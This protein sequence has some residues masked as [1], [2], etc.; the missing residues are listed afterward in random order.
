MKRIGITGSLASGKSTATK[1]LG[2]KGPVFNADKTVKKLY[3]QTKIRKYI[4]KKL[5]IQNSS[6]LKSL[7][8][9]KILKDKSFFKKIEKIIHPLVRKEMVNFA[10]KHKGKKFIFF[11]IPLLVE[12]RLMKNFDIVIFIKAKRSLRLKRFKKKGGDKILFDVLNRKQFSTK[13]KTRHCDYV[14][15]NEKNLNILKKNLL[16]ILKKYE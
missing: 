15:V 14:V 13:K 8:K 5:K 3:L 2:K 12:S 9:K 1:I 11:E 10:K 7:V 4:S 16:D 6:N